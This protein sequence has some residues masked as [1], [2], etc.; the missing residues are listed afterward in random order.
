MAQDQM[1]DENGERRRKIRDGFYFVANDAAA[2]GDVAKQAAG[3][4]VLDAAFVAKFFNFADVVEDDA[5]QQQVGIEFGILLEDTAA[6]ADEAD[7]VFEQAADESVMHHH[8]GGSAFEFQGGGGV[9]DNALQQAFQVR[10]GHACDFSAELGVELLDVIFGVGEKIAEIVFALFGGNNLLE[11]DFFLAVVEFDAATD[12]DYVV[13]FEGLGDGFEVVPHF[14][15][16]GAGAIA[17]GKL[18][19][20]FA[21]GGGANS[22]L[23]DEEKG[24][25]GLAILQIRN[26]MRFH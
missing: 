13:T 12:Y 7:D 17:Q 2:D 19:P 15:R 6:E 16:D 18:Q 11:S 25:D 3:R 5:T 20:G 23:A 22:L 10:I 8:G 4:G 26:E 24:G 1:F 9:V 14:G 21:A